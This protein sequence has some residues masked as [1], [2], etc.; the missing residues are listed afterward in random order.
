[1]FSD[2]KVA[3][4]PYSHNRQQCLRSCELKGQLL[5]T[6]SELLTSLRVKLDN[7]MHLVLTSLCW[8]VASTFLSHHMYQ[9]RADSV[10]S[11]DLCNV[12][13]QP[14]VALGRM[15]FCVGNVLL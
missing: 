8:D 6:H 12:A 2:N 7:T 15:S 1:M 5:S 14:G 9:Y 3:E 13:M 4:F 11:T 10:G